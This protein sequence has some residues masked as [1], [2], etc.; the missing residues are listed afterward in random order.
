MKFR[1]ALKMTYLGCEFRDLGSGDGRVLI[2]A[3]KQGF[4]PRGVELNY[5]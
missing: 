5:W 1:K 4:M 2:A 3:G